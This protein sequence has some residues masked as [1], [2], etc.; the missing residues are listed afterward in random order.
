[1]LLA[2][3]IRQAD[4]C[5]ERALR[6]APGDWL[7]RWMAARIRVFWGQ[8]V[9]ALTLAQEALALAPDRAVAWITAGECQQALG[10]IHAARQSAAHAL[11]LEPHNPVA[12][13]LVR[14]LENPGWI[15]AARGW[16]QRLGTT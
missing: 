11:T 15:A 3:G 4:A 12:L 1:V 10:L 13:E 8:F 16:L 2:S 14:T 5:F 6:L 7:T 9:P